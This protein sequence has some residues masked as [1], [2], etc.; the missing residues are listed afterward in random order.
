[1]LGC[2]TAPLAAFF[3]YLCLLININSSALKSEAEATQ[4]TFKAA[5]PQHPRATCGWANVSQWQGWGHF[6][7]PVFWS[8]FAS[9]MVSSFIAGLGDHQEFASD[10]DNNCLYGR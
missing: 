6:L 8:S 7:Q 10:A 2:L 4:N 9:N 3:T 5:Q 1:M